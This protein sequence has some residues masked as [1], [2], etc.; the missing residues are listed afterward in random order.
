MPG[1]SERLRAA[2]AEIWQAQHEH[3]FVLGIGDGTLGEERFRFWLRQ[4]YVFLAEY[5]RLLALAAA[6]SPDLAT[7]TRFADLVYET[8][9]EEMDLHRAYAAEFGITP[10]ELAGE[11]P[12]PTTRGYTD[13]LLR[14]ASVG[15]FADLLA[16]LLPCMWGFNEI[17]LSLAGRAAPARSAY[18]R[19]IAMYS[20]AEF[21]ALVEWLRDLTDRLGEGLPPSAEARLREVF[22]ASSRYELAFWEMAWYRETWPR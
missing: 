9:H 13:F 20:S 8:L 12:S 17:G 5:A 21:T 19:W 1:L 22:L 15:D 10:D 4:D 7:M 11:V 3:P 16:A 6:R 14:S 2:A 18:A